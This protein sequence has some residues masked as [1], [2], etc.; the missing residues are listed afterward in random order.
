M[1]NDAQKGQGTEGKKAKKFVE[2]SSLG[3][4]AYQHL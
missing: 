2:G 4:A 3:L 1:R